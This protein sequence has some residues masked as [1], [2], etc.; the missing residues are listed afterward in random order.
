M[1]S[2]FRRI[3]NSRT[4][5]IVTF[6]V[7]GV[8]ALA[9][10]AGDVTGLRTIGAP[11][12]ANVASVGGAP[13]SAIDL[14]K[15]VQDEMQAFRQQQPTLDLAQFVNG[16]G[17]EGT[18][19]RMINTIALERFGNAQGMRVSKQVVDSEIASIPALQGPD[20]KFSQTVYERLLQQRK[21]T[22]AQIRQEIARSILTNQLT[23][24]TVGASQVPDQLALPYASLL[25]E[26][27]AGELGFL[28]YRAMGAGELPK[29]AELT[30]FYSLN[31]A[32]YTIPERRVI[33]YALVSP[34]KVKDAAAL[35]D[36]EIAKAYQQQASR[37]AA[38]EKR[39]LSQVV[40]G[41]KAAAE[42]LAA[43]VK[44]GT[45]ISAAAQ[46]IGLD[47]AKISGVDRKAYTE[48]T[49]PA[50]AAAV[51]GS[52]RGAVVGPLQAPL[53]WSVVQVDSI[54]QV[55]AKTLDQARPELVKELGADKAA[56]AF[57]DLHDRIDDAISNKATFAEIVADQ[58][59]QAVTTPPLLADGRNVAQP[60]AAPDP[61]LA[62]IIK[63]GF[64]AETGDDPQLV[65]AGADGTFAVVSLERVVPAAAPPAAQLREVLLRDFTIDRARRKARSVAAQLVAQV[66]KGV[67]LADAL[68]QTKLGLAPVQ[69]IETSRAALSANPQG[70]PPPLALMFAMKAKTAKLLEAPEQGGWLIVYLDR[71]QPADATGKPAII[72]AMRADIGKVIGR[73]YIQQFSEAVRRQLG[74]TKNEAALAKAKQALLGQQGAQP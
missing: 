68:A 34:D 57:A 43:K 33:R 35:T 54:E 55:A 27:R 19:E 74:V 9:F 16:G 17:F 11:S 60:Q 36:A 67:P 6:I 41:D 44:S 7:L 52:A 69:K 3:I 51:F 1:L 8:I 42:A 13:I 45:A 15:R 21:L 37:F 46:A 31:R 40:I 32:R 14:E 18:L 56:R 64:A 28:P 38:S 5:V 61:A 26:R 73:E 50:I 71:I 49:S 20:G 47:A 24:P 53:G 25:L 62:Q 58:K 66:N 10:A 29:D 39:T 2:F 48:Q 4:G 12:T 59:L 70:A 63:A 22:D 23:A 72:N 30:T 65:P